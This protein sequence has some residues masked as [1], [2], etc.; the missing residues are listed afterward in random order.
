MKIEREG[1]CWFVD[2]DLECVICGSAIHVE[3]R[4]DILDRVLDHAG[5]RVEAVQI[6]CP[7]CGSSLCAT[8]HGVPS[9]K[10]WRDP[11]SA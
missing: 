2:L 1:T 3:D 10:P 4:Y 6:E 8:Y 7:H 9:T 11:W 5:T